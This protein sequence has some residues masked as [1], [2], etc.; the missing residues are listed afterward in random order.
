MS[1]IGSAFTLTGN[2]NSTKTPQFAT[3]AAQTRR[4][5]APKYHVG[6]CNFTG[7]VV[8]GVVFYKVTQDLFFKFVI[9]K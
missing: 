3:N 4:S 9:K 6:L 1:S 8:G 7:L 2:R 5:K